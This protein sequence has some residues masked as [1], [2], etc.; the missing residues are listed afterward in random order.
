M[1]N[2]AEQPQALKLRGK[3]ALKLPDN[4]DKIGRAHV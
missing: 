4:I 2:R 3:V 1:T